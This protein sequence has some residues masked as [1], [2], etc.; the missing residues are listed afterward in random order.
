MPRP[1][2]EIGATGLPLYS[3]RLFLDTNRRL[4][5]PDAGRIYRDM[6][7][8]EPAAGALRTAVHSLL[9][10]D[11]QVTPGGRAMRRGRGR[12]AAE[13]KAAEHVE[14]CLQD[15]RQPFG[16]LLRQMASSY[17]YG[18]SIHELVYKRRPD[19]LVG[20]A[21]WGLR[22]QETLDKWETTKGRVTAFTQ[23]PAPDYVLRTI[24]LTK[25]IHVLADDADG[26][27]EGRGALRAMYR[28]WYMLTQFEL[29]MGIALERF[30]TGLPVFERVDAGIDLTPEQEDSLA[31]QA[32]ALRQNE[33]AYV[34]LPPG[35]KFRF[36]ASPGLNAETY[37]E[38]I[39]VF[40]T[41][42]LTTSLA[43]FIA[44]GMGE[45]G[46]DLGAKK[47]D[48]FLTSLTGLQNKICEAINRQAVPKLLAANGWEVENPPVVALPAVREYDLQK[49]GSFAMVLSKIGA[50]HATPRDEEWFRKISDLADVAIEDLER[51]HEEGKEEPEPPAGGTDPASGEDP[52]AEDMG[53]GEGMD[54]AMED[55]AGRAGA[56]PMMEDEE[57]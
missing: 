12:P 42:M 44:Q 29:L 1:K 38:T 28:Y 20:W 46:V 53:E 48:L 18:F 7:D 47:I 14:E 11:V 25:A 16:T 3:G 22:R 19:G 24:P 34:L 4:R 45:R 30:G 27:P 31:E 40:R 51:L 17:F 35:I 5:W 36:E 13:R 43:E 8:N 39:K 6:L 54:P 41:W 37:L 15:M 55:G 56:D 57:V 52:E 10:T 33:Q 49:L 23:R 9:R 50:F 21:D 32:A 26:S 2:A